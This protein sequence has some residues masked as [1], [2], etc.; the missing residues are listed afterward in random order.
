MNEDSTKQIN[1]VSLNWEHCMS[2]AN[3]SANSTSIDA[4]MHNNKIIGNAT[5]ISDTTEV[6]TQVPTEVSTV[7][8]LPP[9]SDASFDPKPTHAHDDIQET[10]DH[11]I[12]TTEYNHGETILKPI[13]SEMTESFIKEFPIKDIEIVD[14]EEDSVIAP[15]KDK[16]MQKESS[17]I[18]DHNSLNHNSK[19]N[20]S[21][22]ID[23]SS[24]ENKEESRASSSDIPT[25]SHPEKKHHPTPMELL[26]QQS[27]SNTS[28]YQ[29]MYNAGIAQASALQEEILLAAD[30]PSKPGEFD[31][32]MWK[33][34]KLSGMEYRYQ[35]RQ[36]WM[37]VWETKMSK[38][39]K[40]HSAAEADK[41]IVASKNPESH[42]S[43]SSSVSSTSTVKGP[44][45]SIN[46]Q[47]VAVE[48]LANNSKEM[49]KTDNVN[50]PFK[51]PN[52]QETLKRTPVSPL[53]LPPSAINKSLSSIPD[54]ISKKI[55]AYADSSSEVEDTEREDHN[56][57]NNE[58]FQ[59]TLQISLQAIQKTVEQKILEQTQQQQEK[60]QALQ[61]EKPISNEKVLSSPLEQVHD[62]FSS[63]SVILATSSHQSSKVRQVISPTFPNTKI[64]MIKPTPTSVN[65]HTPANKF[66][67]SQEKGETRNSATGSV[68]MTEFQELVQLSIFH[69]RQ[70]LVNLRSS[71]L[72]VLKIIQ[73]PDLLFQI[74][75]RQLE[76][77]LVCC[78]K[79]TALDKI[80]TTYIS[81]VVTFNEE[82]IVSN[83]KKSRGEPYFSESLSTA[84]TLDSADFLA[85]SMRIVSAI[86]SKRG[87]KN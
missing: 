84:S 53:I 61:N 1:R 57:N 51:I 50:A 11:I 87:Q 32:F 64:D 77:E 48:K 16:N 23:T 75:F 59:K 81:A 67:L 12:K 44:H 33:I 4:G 18:P 56:E 63:K 68:D 36:L 52:P 29:S 9:L 55:Y 2:I 54:A 26:Q 20:N 41:M 76:S 25:N 38:C 78:V 49:D 66:S 6:P 60:S 73:V 5:P 21:V 31:Y 34:N 30:Q 35:C 40:L 24:L 37:D 14:D 47:S 62:D 43:S 80:S 45:N 10:V 8:I 85:L 28:N 17:T 86:M 27:N 79:K 83:V 19:R 69:R 65:K 7:D 82:L 15:D 3:S 74:A 58:L 13:I 70:I 39:T 22:R 46:F 42:S 71:L 72:Q